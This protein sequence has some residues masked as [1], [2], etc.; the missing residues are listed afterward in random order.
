VTRA[1]FAYAAALAALAAGGCDSPIVGAG[2]Q[3]SFTLCGDECVNLAADFRHCGACELSCGELS[4]HRGRCGGTRPDAS[5]PDTGAP[6]EDAG[7]APVPPRDAGPAGCTVGERECSGACVDPTN[8]RRHCG[9]CGEPCAE[10]EVCSRGSC[11]SAC[12]SGLRAC[13]GECHDLNTD[14]NNCGTCGTKCASGICDAAECADAILGQLVVIGHDFTEANLAMQRI[15]GNAVFLASGAPVRVLAYRGD[16]SEASVRGVEAAIEFARSEIGRTWEVT[17]AEEE[18][19]TM[20]LAAA[21]VFLIHAQENA[22]ADTLRRLGDA[23]GRAIVQF[24]ARGGNVV[25][26]EAPS[27]SNDGTYHVLDAAQIF[28]AERRVEISVQALTVKT[29]GLGVGLRVPDRYM[30]AT[31]TVRFEALESDGNAIVVEQDGEP[32]VIQRVVLPP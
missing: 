2:C 29:P 24:L 1:T 27:S 6:D 25:L 8:D 20:Q 11:A 13:S 16:A 5:F 12:E 4:C 14:P 22:S 23:W 10:G 9:G 3:P 17:K 28:G 7:T 19:V 30:S 21:D 15:A 26:F 31:H 32:V 18:M